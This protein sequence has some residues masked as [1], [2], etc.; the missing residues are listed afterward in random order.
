MPPEPHNA[1]LYLFSAQ[2]ALI[3]FGGRSYRRRSED[4]SA[5]LVQLFEG[6]QAEGL[7]VPFT[8][9]DFRRQFAKESLRRLSPKE[10]AVLIE[11]LPPEE[12]LAGLTPD[13][14]RQYLE[15]QPA[16][17]PAPARKPRRKS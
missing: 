9:D 15:R 11:S 5:L 3:E 17:R 4:T 12:R 1:H 16:A 13:Q 14:I 6:L 8:M 10:R 7:P 2:P